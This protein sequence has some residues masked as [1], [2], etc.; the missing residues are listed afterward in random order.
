MP[1][2]EI[3][4]A[5][6]RPAIGHLGG[7][8]RLHCT[9][10]YVVKR[11]LAAVLTGAVGKVSRHSPHTSGAVENCSRVGLG[12]EVIDGGELVDDGLA[13]RIN[14]ACVSAIDLIRDS[15]SSSG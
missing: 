12:C 1:P 6:G 11:E 7:I 2:N 10:H 5:C 4:G 3:L 15:L 14:K 9:S 13:G 8:G